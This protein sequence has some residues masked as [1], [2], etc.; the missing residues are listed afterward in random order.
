M[1]KSRLNF[2]V[3]FLMLIIIIF[4][5]FQTNFDLSIIMFSNVYIGIIYSLIILIF[6]QTIFNF[7]IIKNKLFYYVFFIPSLIYPI[8]KCYF[9]IPYV[10]CTSCPKKCI[11]GHLREFILPS[12]VLINIDKRK[13]CFNYCPFGYLQDLNKNFIKKKI[14]LP[15]IFTITK[16]LILLSIPYLLFFNSTS[17]VKSDYSIT[18]IVLIITLLIFSF[19]F[20]IHRFFC[21]Y[22][23]PVGTI[24]D[25]I[26]KFEKWL[27]KITKN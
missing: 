18:L 8:I 21:N 16:Y 2:I 9:K 11:W 10:F 14:K 6:I 25:L 5:I 22:I 27:K 17:F 20:F 13:W 1:K 7:Q 3:T 26:L 23:C 24:G 15:K 4:F 19:S 12:F